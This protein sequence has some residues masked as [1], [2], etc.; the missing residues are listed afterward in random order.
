[1]HGYGE[2]F[3]PTTN[4]AERLRSFFLEHH[5]YTMEVRH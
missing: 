5:S 4:P 2:R 3:D 1:M